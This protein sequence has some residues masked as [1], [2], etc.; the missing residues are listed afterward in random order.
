MDCHQDLAHR[1]IAIGSYCSW[2][3]AVE[4]HSA[5]ALAVARVVLKTGGVAT[6][7]GLLDPGLLW[8]TEVVAAAPAVTTLLTKLLLAE[9]IGTPLGCS[10][11]NQGDRGGNCG[12]SNGKECEKSF[13][14]FDGFSPLRD[15]HH[16]LVL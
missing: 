5:A 2:D 13:H 7:I 3:S 1:V 12:R 15:G 6:A 9:S 10:W 11:L 4:V 8:R 16:P 14:C